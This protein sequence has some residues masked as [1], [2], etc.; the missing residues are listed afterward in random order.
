MIEPVDAYQRAAALF[1]EMISTLAD[2]EWELP[3]RPESWNVSS[4]VA[5]VVV[6]DAQIT[7]ALAVFEKSVNVDELAEK[8]VTTST[9]IV[10]PKMFEFEIIQRAKAKNQHQKNR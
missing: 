6:G 10:T 3:T 2:G 4:T 1:G 7:R 5:W 8:V 9:Q